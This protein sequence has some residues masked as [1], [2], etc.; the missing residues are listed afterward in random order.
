MNYQNSI[1]KLKRLSKINTS[2]IVENSSP[3]NSDIMLPTRCTFLWD[4][5]IVHWNGDILGCCINYNRPFSSGS[6]SNILERMNSQ[7]LI[8]T[9]K[10]L[11]DKLPLEAMSRENPCYDCYTLRDQNIFTPAKNYIQAHYKDKSILKSEDITFIRLE[12]TTSCQ[13]NCPGCWRNISPIKN[14]ITRGYLKPNDL[15]TLLENSDLKHIT[16]LNLSANGE[17]LLNPHFIELLKICYNH[18][19]ETSADTGFNL[20]HI[21]DEQIEAIVDTKM[22]FI[23]LSID[24][25]SQETYSRYRINGNFDKVIENIKRL[26]AYKQKVNSKYPKLLWKMII[27]NWNIHEIDKARKMAEELDIDFCLSKN[28]CDFVD[29]LTLENKKIFEEQ[30][31][32]RLD[33]LESAKEGIFDRE[34][35][36]SY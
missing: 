29:N 7:Y 27:F 21:T 3:N 19:I 28:S 16:K 24:G 6:F 12:L 30:S 5:P 1:Q 32:K 31:G 22:D 20:N 4:Q 25:A 9:R 11:L 2:S 17:S 35:T 34:I 10:I 8:E 15:K 26:Q 18:N 14:N 36:Y 13:L 33:A 23:C